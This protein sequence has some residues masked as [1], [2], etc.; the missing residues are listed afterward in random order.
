ME[1]ETKNNENIEDVNDE[2]VENDDNEVSND[3]E[4]QESEDQD[5]TEDVETNE[6]A[7]IEPSSYDVPDYIGD[8]LKS[9]AAEQKLSNEQ[10]NSI[11]N[12]FE[13]Y[14]GTTAKAQ[15]EQLA[16]EG[17]KFISN[18]GDK[19]EQNVFLAKRALEIT[20]PNGELKEM[21]NKTGYGNHP[22]VLQYFY[23]LGKNL[24]EGGFIKSS[25]RSSEDKR[26]TAQKLYPSMNT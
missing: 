5:T 20:D 21:L 24:S 3:Q 2:H 18:W 19:A 17:E 14:L 8:D 10:F 26:S 9:F 16:K 25:N 4:K 15:M 6:T 22:M 7:D 23:N 11:I 13:G 12:K 1:E